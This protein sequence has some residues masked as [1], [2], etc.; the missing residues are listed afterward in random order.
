MDILILKTNINSKIDFLHV[1]GIL[2]YFLDVKE[3]TIDLEDC[4]KVMRIIGK[5]FEPAE[6]ISRQMR[7]RGRA[8]VLYNR[9]PHF[10]DRPASPPHIKNNDGKDLRSPRN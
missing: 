4:D 7:I 3:V 1:K 2:R 6:I 5:N 9:P 10:T 8:I